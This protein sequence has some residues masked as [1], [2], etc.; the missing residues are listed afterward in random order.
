PL[1]AGL[2]LLVAEFID[3]DELGGID[4]DERRPRLATLVASFAIEEPDAE[5]ILLAVLLL[6]DE[7][8]RGVGLEALQLFLEGLALALQHARLLGHDQIDILAVGLER[9]GESVEIDLDD[10]ALAYGA[11]RFLAIAFALPGVANADADEGIA[12]GL[13]DDGGARLEDV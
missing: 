6:D 4:L 9:D 7:V 3:W 5:E 1:E 11:R 10:L 13:E 12:V 2:V 8:D